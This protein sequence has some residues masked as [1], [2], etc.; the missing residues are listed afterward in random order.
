MSNQSSN[1]TRILIIVL[2]IVLLVGYV[3]YQRV[4]NP[5]SSGY[6][7]NFFVPWGL[8]A[9]VMSFYFFSETNRV[10][11]AK[12]DERREHI[13]ERRQEILTTLRYKKQEEL[14]KMIK[15]IPDED[16]T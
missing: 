15:G 16:I 9:V 10:R 3:I 6:R 1:K 2:V 7:V 13:D 11:K 5:G 4:S 8:I 12:R 14:A